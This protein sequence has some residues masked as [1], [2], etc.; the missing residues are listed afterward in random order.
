MTEIWTQEISTVPWEVTGIPFV[1]ACSAWV[2]LVLVSTAAHTSEEWTGLVC[3]SV[4]CTSR[5]SML[6]QPFLCPLFRKRSMAVL[7]A[8]RSWWN[9]GQASG[10][11]TH[12][13]LSGGLFQ[14]SSHTAP[15]RLASSGA[16]GSWMNGVDTGKSRNTER[17][18]WATRPTRVTGSSLELCV[19]LWATSVPHMQSVSV[20]GLSLETVKP[21]CHEAGLYQGG[22]ATPFVDASLVAAFMLLWRNG[23]VVTSLPG[24]QSLKYL[25]SGP[26]Q[27]KLAKQRYLLCMLNWHPRMYLEW[28]C[29][30]PS[31]GELRKSHSN[32]FVCSVTWEWFCF[33]N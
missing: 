8:G 9:Q 25:P 18:V 28:L 16:G 33:L 11:Q 12:S 14:Y 7:Q 15:L 31:S 22:T 29:Y 32:G 2:R 19:H 17:D 24:S 5:P 20:A 21:R 10:W 3:V 4:H 13:D 23:V 26:L 1:G 30:V 27:K 6:K